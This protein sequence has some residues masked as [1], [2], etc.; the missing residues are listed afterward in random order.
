MI[1]DSDVALL[2]RYPRAIYHLRSRLRE[3]KLMPVFGSGA[4]SP[5]GLP[6]W[7][8]LV[9]RIAADPR[10][11]ALRVAEGTVSQSSRIQMIFHHF[12][13]QQ[14]ERA[15][16]E[17]RGDDS[18]FERRTA[19]EWREIV[20]SSL[21][22]KARAVQEHPYLMYF[23][24]IIQQAPLTVNYNFDDAIQELIDLHAEA[25][26]DDRR[27]FETIWDPTVQFRYQTSVIYHPNGFLP[28]QLHRDPSPR[29]VFLE[30]T[31]ADQ[32][33]DAQ[34]GHYSTL[35]SHYYRF[36]ALLIG[37]SLEDATLRHLLRQNAQ[38]NP[39]HV[40]YYVAY[41]PSDYP[42]EA[43]REA[44]RHSNFGTY[45]LVTLF[46]T[47]SDI[48]SLGRLI[49]AADNEFANAADEA[50]L[51]PNFVYYLTGAVG[52]GKTSALACFKS[53]RSHDEW[54][55][56]KPP[57]LHQAADKLTESERKKVNEW[58]DRQMRQRNLAIS[59]RSFDLAIVDRSPLDPIAFATDDGASRAQELRKLYSSS[60]G[61]K[62]VAGMLVLLTGSAEVMH[63]R[64]LDRHK[65]A[66]P[67]YIER[68]QNRFKALW[69]SLS[70]SVVVINT[71]DVSIPE[72]V[73]KISRVIHLGDYN[74]A[75][76]EEILNSV[77]KSG[78]PA[79]H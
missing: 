79:S 50:Q 59:N 38:F 47:D 5:I 52:A 17:A 65:H 20:H 71:I 27:G 6:N 31:F 75:Q 64:T 77:E 72:V 4:S 23:L 61:K 51:P 54:P 41:C 28:R 57:L 14:M 19:K 10:V 55:D 30:D 24:P 78:L 60:M 26:S 33:L 49:G 58:I 11:D 29:L 9:N 7:R 22:A 46:L 69:S 36:T 40:H 74:E 34:R 35:L 8:E 3:K 18:I 48:Q 67:G 53:L 42:S 2:E 32:M 16:A 66:D 37:L 44:I 12:R 56:E 21:Y 39:G 76:L 25:K 43:R 73:Q 15:R 1:E 63:G 68:L 70:N 62:P 13:N 45:N